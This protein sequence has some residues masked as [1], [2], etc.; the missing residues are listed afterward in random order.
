MQKL[1]NISGN[2]EQKL[3]KPNQIHI[4]RNKKNQLEYNFR[5]KNNNA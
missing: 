1:Y 3:V 2:L 5:R 4:P